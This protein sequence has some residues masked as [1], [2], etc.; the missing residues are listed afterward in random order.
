MLKTFKFFRTHNEEVVE[1]VID[2]ERVDVLDGKL[3]VVDERGH[4]IASFAE[5]DINS[6]HKLEG[7]GAISTVKPQGA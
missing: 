3:T 2:G 5:S 7:A 4:T 1:V 6:W